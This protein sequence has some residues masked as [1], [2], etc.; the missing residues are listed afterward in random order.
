MLTS[1]YVK[2]LSSFNDDFKRKKESTFFR[3]F[4][5]SL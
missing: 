4:Y 3:E 5:L 2:K 1:S